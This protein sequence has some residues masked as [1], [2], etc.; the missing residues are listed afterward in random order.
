M[1]VMKV[2]WSS[3]RSVR[4]TLRWCLNETSYSKEKVRGQDELLE[5]KHNGFSFRCN[6]QRYACYS[7]SNSSNDIDIYNCN[8]QFW[9][10]NSSDEARLYNIGK[11]IGFTSKVT[12]ECVVKQINVMNYRG[13][14]SSDGTGKGIHNPDVWRGLKVGG[15]GITSRS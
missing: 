9:T 4:S 11:Q 8:R 15:N 7:L 1:W 14:W 6:S 10:R 13:N 5:A 12:D 3:S 2:L